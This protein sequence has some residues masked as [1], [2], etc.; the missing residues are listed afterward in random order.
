MEIIGK[1]REDYFL[2]DQVFLKTRIR[3]NFRQ[4]FPVDEETQRNLLLTVL[5]L[6]FAMEPDGLSD[7][8]GERIEDFELFV[9]VNINEC[10][11]MPLYSGYAYDAFLKLV[12]SCD[13]PLE[14]FRYVWRQKT[15]SVN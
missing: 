10:G 8:Y 13:S 11:F 1:E 15:K 4:F 14:L 9:D 7:D 3:D 6:N 12:L 5:F 2:D